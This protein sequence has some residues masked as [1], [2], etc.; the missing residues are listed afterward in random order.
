[1]KLT[2]DRLSLFLAKYL[3]AVALFYSP[4]NVLLRYVIPWGV[5]A[6]F[7]E[8]NFAFAILV[9]FSVHAVTGRRYKLRASLIDV[10]MLGWLVYG[11]IA[12]LMADVKSTSLPQSVGVVRLMFAAPA[13]Y[14]FFRI[15]VRDASGFR[16]LVDFMHVLLKAAIVLILVEFVVANV[17][18]LWSEIDTFVKNVR[19]DT[20]GIYY[21][22]FTLWYRPA[23]PI[24]GQQHASILCVIALVAFHLRSREEAGRRYLWWL[25]AAA[26]GLV[27]TITITALLVLLTI[28]LIANLK[29]I[30]SSPARA[31]SAVMIAAM[32]VVMFIYR[33]EIL[34]LRAGGTEGVGLT[35][36]DI[37][38]LY[39]G[40]L[41]EASRIFADAFLEKP[42]GVGWDVPP[43]FNLDPMGAFV[44]PEIFILRISYY[45]GSVFFVWFCVFHLYL[46]VRYSLARGTRG[47]D[48]LVL[49]A[50]CIIFALFLSTAHYDSFV[51]PGFAQVYAFAVALL[52]SFLGRSRRQGRM[53][54]E[55]LASSS[56]GLTLS[57]DAG[58]P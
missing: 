8:I 6:S 21:D 40:P 39:E 11:L 46:F 4:I 19:P 2:V 30:L 3:L 29:K 27:L 17:F 42:F 54:R 32:L 33:T 58:P 5:A 48:P 25:A 23:G 34:S 9:L 7:L 14:F 28:I 53:S 44:P 50:Y 56:R 57:Q 10:G 55:N 35:G 47:K 43:E 51:Q 18:G 52:A 37:Q 22:V 26:L 31:A 49:F 36:V 38:S 15:A 24:F 20:I 16:E 13:W 45:L 1:L 41:E 12:L